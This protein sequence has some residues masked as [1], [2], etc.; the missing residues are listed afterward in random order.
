MSRTVF[1][2]LMDMVREIAVL[3]GAIAVLI[4]TAVGG[5]WLAIL[6]GLPFWVGGMAAWLSVLGFAVFLLVVEHSRKIGAEN[7]HE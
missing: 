4:V 1:L 6:I 7:C 5:I 3:G 2:F